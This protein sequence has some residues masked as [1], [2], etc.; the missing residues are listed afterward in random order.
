M[1]LLSRSRLLPERVIWLECEHWRLLRRLGL[2]ARSYEVQEEGRWSGSTL[3]AWCY[4]AERAIQSARDRRS[5][6]AT[7][8]VSSELAPGFGVE[9]PS[10]GAPRK[11]VQRYLG[12]RREQVF[13]GD[14]Y[15][16][17]VSTASNLKSGRGLAFAIPEP[18]VRAVKAARGSL[19]PL[20]LM[21]ASAWGSMQLGIHRHS[22]DHWYLQTEARRT[23]GLWFSGGCAQRVAVLP[24]V[25][26]LDPE[27]DLEPWNRRFGIGPSSWTV[28]RTDRDD[29]FR[30][31]GEVSLFAFNKAAPSA[32]VSVTTK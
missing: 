8:C 14:D 26:R 21:P 17:R 23:L 13:G 16:W 19:W 10:G 31:D 4:G 18:F 6:G 1:S 20:R 11:D 27:T 24:P 25:G 30:F 32:S 9:L 7:L 12:V 3:E 15:Q 28:G 29:A 22:S 5:W 2:G